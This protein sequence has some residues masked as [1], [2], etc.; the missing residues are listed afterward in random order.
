MFKW[1]L[2]FSL[3]G[4]V[5]NVYCIVFYRYCDINNEIRSVIF[6]LFYK[7]V[8]KIYELI[9]FL[10]IIYVYYLILFLEVNCVL[11]LCLLLDM[12]V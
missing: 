1:L 4:W 9:N 6:K 5:F 8:I 10:E 7:E 3:K 11:K 2:F 12:R